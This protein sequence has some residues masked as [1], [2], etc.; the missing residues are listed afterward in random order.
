MRSSYEG[1]KA[2]ADALV[3]EAKH[4][5]FR[6]RTAMAGKSGQWRVP[7]SSGYCIVTLGN[8]MDGVHIVPVPKDDEDIAKVPRIRSGA[9]LDQGQITEAQVGIDAEGKPILKPAL[10]CFNMTSHTMEEYGSKRALVLS[11]GLPVQTHVSMPTRLEATFGNADSQYTLQ[12]ASKY[13]G[14]MCKL[15]QTVLS[16]GIPMKEDVLSKVM[17]A[18]ALANPSVLF[19]QESSLFTKENRAGVTN[20]FQWEYACTH[21]LFEHNEVL[22]DGTII[23]E[24]WLIEISTGNGIRAM[25]L[26]L[27]PV[28]ATPFFKGYI[29]AQC[30]KEGHKGFYDDIKLILDEF[31]GYPTNEGFLTKHHKKIITL[32]EPGHMKEYETGR[33]VGTD[34]GWAFNSKGTAANNICLEDMKDNWFKAHHCQITIG[35]DKEKR[36]PTAGFVVLESGS[37]P[38]GHGTL[39]VGDSIM[40]ACVTYNMEHL[41]HAVRP[42][43]A[44]A[45]NTA[46]HVFYKNDKLIVLRYTEGHTDPTTDKTETTG[47]PSDPYNDYSTETWSGACGTAA[48]FFYDGFDGR[49]PIFDTH[50]KCSA[51]RTLGGERER[52]I[53]YNPASDSP[54]YYSRSFWWRQIEKERIESGSTTWN[55]CAFLPLGDRSAFYIVNFTQE[56]SYTEQQTVTILSRGDPYT[57]I[58]NDTYIWNFDFGTKCGTKYPFKFAGVTLDG[59][60]E[61]IWDR[62]GAKGR[63]Q[64][65]HY[66]QYYVVAPMGYHG[67]YYYGW[68]PELQKDLDSWT[69]GTGK[70]EWFSIGAEPFTVPYTPCDL[71]NPGNYF[72]AGGKLNRLHVHFFSI[73]KVG[74]VFERVGGYTQIYRDYYYWFDPSPNS[75]GDFQTMWNRRN[76]LGDAKYQLWSTDVND[77][78]LSVGG[79]YPLWHDNFPTFIG[80]VGD[81]AA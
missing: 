42:G 12:Q 3:P 6:Y 70:A 22:E 30:K 4:A 11:L 64:L 77:S 60:V 48:G 63:T 21:G 51:A 59:V 31:G 8:G 81:L 62:S 66:C 36:T 29:A 7:L 32:L 37:A 18:Y 38:L 52:V 14:K 45:T 67:G 23:K 72:K 13:T 25:P 15:V 24:N 17:M 43:R 50:R 20:Q 5:F 28:T 69:A 73:E 71:E 58:V 55:N 68:S 2:A 41:L 40:D 27:E 34:V 76:C 57:Y 33:G 26:Q 49:L 79:G 47:D 10:D 65:D 80:V 35:Y 53:T 54:E 75:D 46:M 39:K 9:V 78:D 1:D 74:T 16:Y 44:A 61:V 56:P 19:K